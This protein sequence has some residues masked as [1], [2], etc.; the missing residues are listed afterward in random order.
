[1]NCL[2]DEI[3]RFSIDVAYFTPV[4]KIELPTL[5]GALTPGS[6]G[7]GRVPH[8]VRERTRTFCRDK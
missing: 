8:E 4:S 5:G 2:F 7:C 6:K 1:M 3:P